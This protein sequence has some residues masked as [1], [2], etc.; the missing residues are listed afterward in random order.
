MEKSCGKCGQTKPEVG[1]YLKKGKPTSWC[2]ECYR[3]WHRERY[4]PKT[5]ADDSP[6][7]CASCGESF[8]PKTRRPAKFCS[9][10]CKETDR[11]ESGAARARHLLRTFG[12]TA[13][14]YDA[15]LAAQ[16]GGC[17][18]CGC[19]PEEQAAR[20]T[21]FLH[22]DHDHTTGRVRGLLCAEHNLLL[23]RFNDDPALL[24]RAVEY[25]EAPAS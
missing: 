14:E 18:I 2:K 11:K 24:R 12:I 17:A 3:E 22:V 21:T 13:E 16:G 7:A 20:Y 4:A 6:R 1:F 25:L 19:R 23:G 5:G 8:R 9:V 10:A 15:M